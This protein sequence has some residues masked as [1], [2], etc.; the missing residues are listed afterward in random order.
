LPYLSYERAYG[1]TGRAAERAYVDRTTEW[2]KRLKVPQ[3]RS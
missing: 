3:A 2:V 1:L